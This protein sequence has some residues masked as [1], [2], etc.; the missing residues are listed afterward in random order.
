MKRL[1][2]V[3]LIFIMSNLPSYGQINITQTQSPED[4]V[5]NVLTGNG[6]VISNV[7]YNL[8]KCSRNK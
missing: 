1:R 5:N 6:V 4:L 3:L 2:I 7:T 8:Y